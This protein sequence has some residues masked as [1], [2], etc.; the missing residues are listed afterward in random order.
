MGYI[1]VIAQVARDLWLLVNKPC[2]RATPSDWSA[3]VDQLL[4]LHLLISEL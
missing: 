4:Q 2:P 3:I 1:I